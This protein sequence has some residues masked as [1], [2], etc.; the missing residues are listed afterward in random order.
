MNKLPAQNSHAYRMLAHLRSA[1]DL[2]VAD[3][4]KM[5]SQ[6][7]YL[8]VTNTK[9]D[10]DRLQDRNLIHIKVGVVYL[11]GIAKAEFREIELARPAEQTDVV[12]PRVPR[13]FDTMLNP[14]YFLSLEA[15][16]PDAQPPREIYFKNGGM[17][18]SIGYRL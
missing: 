12:P 6:F 17:A 2:P 8:N 10:L 9:R 5:R 15:R 14:K 7:G 3:L 13:V 1:G 4:L 11:T 18:T 16:R